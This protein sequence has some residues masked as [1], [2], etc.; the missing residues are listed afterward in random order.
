MNFTFILITKIDL[1]FS[2]DVNP[3]KADVKVAEVNPRN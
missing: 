1:L 3:K 2:A